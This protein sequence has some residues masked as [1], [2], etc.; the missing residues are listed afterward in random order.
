MELTL[1]VA[2]NVAMVVT[3]VTAESK[4]RE[5]SGL[6]GAEIDEGRGRTPVL[7]GNAVVDGEGKNE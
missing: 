6:G 5:C 4:C 7:R 2:G 3:E 1:S